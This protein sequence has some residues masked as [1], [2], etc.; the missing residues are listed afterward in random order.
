MVE[1][2]TCV[3][4]CVCVVMW[5]V[6]EERSGKDTGEAKDESPTKTSSLPTHSITRC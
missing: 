6:G 5:G 1:Q 2:S 3:C 4:V